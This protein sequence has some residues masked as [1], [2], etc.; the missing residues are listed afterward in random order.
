L[1]FQQAYRRFHFANDPI[2]AVPPRAKAVRSWSA[3][4]VPHSQFGAG[5]RYVPAATGTIGF[6]SAI[7][8]IFL[9]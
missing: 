9:P 8:M 2:S 1:F 7:L 5:F 4:T 6:V 3:G